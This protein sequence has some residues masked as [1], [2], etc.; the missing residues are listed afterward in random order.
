MDNKETV[1]QELA[2]EITEQAEKTFTQSELDQIIGERLKREREKY[3]DYDA[4]KEKAAKLDQI[5]E[6]AK[7]ELQ[8]AQ[9]RAEKLEAELSAM[10]HSEEVRAIRDKVAQAT[11]VPA[12]LLTGDTEESCNEQAAGILSFKTANPANYPVVRDGG[13]IQKKVEGSTAQQFADY[14]SQV[15]S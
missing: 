11:G 10:K 9:E 7:T 3:P 15:F 6:D 4:L 8:R 13:E 14:M 1:K 2:T 12:S 5:E